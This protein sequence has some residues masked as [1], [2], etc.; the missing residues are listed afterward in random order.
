MSLTRNPSYAI[1]RQ[2][3]LFAAKP[4]PVA[5]KAPPKKSKTRSTDEAMRVLEDARAELIA[6][7]RDEAAALA[8]AHGTVHSRMVRASLEAKGLVHPDEK[9]FWIGAVFRDPRF[10]WTGERYSYSDPARNVHERTVKVWR[11]KET[12]K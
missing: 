11:L 1:I 3:D 5:A 7:A 8:R 6:T 9:E 4:E 2:L 10:E 12:A